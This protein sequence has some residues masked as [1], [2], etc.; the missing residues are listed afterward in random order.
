M[1]ALIATTTAMNGVTAGGFEPGLDD[2]D[3]WIAATPGLGHDR[4]PAIGKAGE[5]A[6][7]RPDEGRS[8][9]PVN[10][11]PA[12]GIDQ[13]SF[14]RELLVEPPHVACEPI[15][16]PSSNAW[17]ASSSSLASCSSRGP[18]S[19]RSRSRA[20]ATVQRPT[21]GYRDRR[22]GPEQDRDEDRSHFSR[23]RR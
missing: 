6:T 15:A 10:Q 16:P 14:A 20:L 21:R 4:E 23:S 22:E 18:T 1:I 7:D 11:V 9:G 3:E 19:G 2:P 13:E 17:L 12:I 8:V 5:A